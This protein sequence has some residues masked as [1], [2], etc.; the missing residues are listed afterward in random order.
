M[1]MLIFVFFLQIAS[2]SVFAQNTYT[3]NSTS[4]NW[5][6]SSKWTPAR[7]SISDSDVIIIDG[8][9]TSTVVIDSFVT[10]RVSRFKIIN[11]ADVTLSAKDVVDTL[12]IGGSGDSLVIESG[13]ALKLSGSK[14]V[15]I[16]LSQTATGSVGGR[17]TLEGGAHRLLSNSERALVFKAG[18]EF[19][20]NTGFTGNPFGTTV[21]NSVCF[22]AGST[23][24]YTAGSNPFGA[25][26]PNSVVSFEHG[27]KFVII[28]AATGLSFNGRTY[29]DIVVTGGLQVTGSGSGNLRFDTLR[30]EPGSSF[31]YNGTGSAKITVLG[32][33]TNGGNINLTAAGSIS[34]EGVEQ[35]MGGSNG[36]ISLT[37]NVNVSSSTVVT[38]KSDLSLNSGTLAAAGTMDFGAHRISGSGSFSLLPGSIMKIADCAGLD[39]IFLITGSKS[40]D[41]EASFFLYGT[42]TEWSGTLAPPKIRNLTIDGNSVISKNLETSG[43][44]EIRSG[45]LNVSRCMLS[46]YQPITG[47]GDLDCDSTAS[48]AIM[49]NMTGFSVPQNIQQLDSLFIGNPNGASLAGDLTVD[50][51]NLAGGKLIAGNHRLKIKTDAVNAGT[52]GYVDDGFTQILEQGKIAKFPLGRNGKYEPI[53]MGLPDAATAKEL[54]ISLTEKDS[55][56]AGI[57]LRGRTLLQAYKLSPEGNWNSRVA[58]LKITYRD[59]DIPNR[60]TALENTIKL[61]RITNGVIEEVPSIA[62]DTSANRIIP[63]TA[64]LNS[65]PQF[66][67]LTVENEDVNSPKIWQSVYR[68]TAEV[69]LANA[70]TQP[71]SDIGRLSFKV[72]MPKVAYDTLVAITFCR[73]LFHFSSGNTVQVYTDKL[74]ISSS[75]IF[76]ERSDTLYLR[77]GT[78]AVDTFN[79]SVDGIKVVPN[80]TSPVSNNGSTADSLALLIVSKSSGNKII[81]S[82]NGG[83][84]LIKLLP[85]ASFRPRWLPSSQFKDTT[86]G[87]NFVA[88][89][90][91]KST[92]QLEIQ[93]MFGNRTN[94]KLSLPALTPIQDFVTP[95][96]ANGQLVCPENYFSR[97]DDLNGGLITYKVLAYDKCEKIKLVAALLGKSDTMPS[98][99]VN[100]FAAPPSKVML[101]SVSPSDVF[102]SGLSAGETATFTIAVVDRYN[103]PVDGTPSWTLP[104]WLITNETKG[105]GG[106]FSPAASSSNIL[107]GD[108]L[109]RS[110]A[111]SGRF[112]SFDLNS[113]RIAY[114]SS[115]FYTGKIVLNF[116]ARTEGNEVLT[117]PLVIE[118]NVTTG[119]P[120]SLHLFT[121]SLRTNPKDPSD[122]PTRVLMLPAESKKF[123]VEFL[124][125]YG[126]HV[127]AVKST[128]VKFSS[129]A[130]GSFLGTALDSL[131]GKAY[132]STIF[133]APGKSN[134]FDDKT[135]NRIGWYVVR[136]SM[137]N[138]GAA[139]SIFVLVK[140]G[141]PARVELL[142]LDSVSLRVSDS[143]RS[144]E[145][146]RDFKF[147]ASDVFGNR[148]AG[149]QLRFAARGSGGFA[150]QDGTGKVQLASD[151]LAQSGYG[152]VEDSASA[153]IVPLTFVS[154]G[155]AGV[156][157]VMAEFN[158]KTLA[159]FPVKIIPGDPV[160]VRFLTKK[161]LARLA[162]QVTHELELTDNFLNRVKAKPNDTSLIRLRLVRGK[163]Y[164]DGVKYLDNENGTIKLNYR[165]HESDPDTAF[166]VSNYLESCDTAMVISEAGSGL[167]VLSIKVDST[168]KFAGDSI[169]VVVASA[170]SNAV[171]LYN[172]SPDSL[173]VSITEARP[174]C[175]C[176]SVKMP[177]ITGERILNGSHGY[178]ALRFDSVRKEVY[179]PQGSFFD[180]KSVLYLHSFGAA[181]FIVKVFDAR[182]HISSAPNRPM[183]F[184]ALG[185][186][187]Y[188]IKFDSTNIS[189]PSV[190]FELKYRVMPLDK[191]GNTN[192][193]SVTL[194]DIASNVGAEVDFGTSPKKILG[195]TSLSL[196]V[197]ALDQTLSA[198]FVVF[199]I[200][201]DD[202]SIQ[203]KSDT[204]RFFVPT[205]VLANEKKPDRFKILGSYPNPFNLSAVIEFELPKSCNVRVL[206][207]DVLGR[208]VKTIISDER[209]QSGRRGV[210]W[211][212]ENS[213]GSISASGIYWYVV[214]AE[215]VRGTGRMVLLK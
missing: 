181:S 139:D 177:F 3:W 142:N 144:S 49:G 125:Q 163:G 57:D 124:D 168:L 150:R 31:S 59:E 160:K 172:Y 23:Y 167:A 202:N 123:R 45:S 68:D 128:T 190:P 15:S 32:N 98:R 213:Q 173:T 12:L 149:Y 109:S 40:F 114:H 35:L 80:F 73:G 42:H 24:N 39:S 51:L 212:G 178:Y 132:L 197:T 200:K 169:R 94:D 61:F 6:D 135:P 29:P 76:G 158:G 126:N 119:S 111:D 134:T 53:E 101:L 1:R 55:L 37:G 171:P 4:G 46:V 165:S 136:A 21:L 14:A 209:A 116:R 207:Y 187:S 44:I 38:L 104:E 188:R 183:E 27:S 115:R 164:L 174:L 83:A 106:Y 151:T 54:M 140:G 58:G 204:V 11:G 208:L 103:N 145:S 199:V 191:F 2:Q 175:I 141:V 110:P 154:G 30:T 203:G 211:N 67:V 87:E 205:G 194:V 162:Q 195:E 91:G 52:N 71:A 155:K 146:S 8:S 193:D 122:L 82:A 74:P 129:S 153:G 120:I 102:S 48:L 148:S 182:A 185:V 206:I 108:M 16:I 97:E 156:D 127:D 69:R 112:A 96:P 66:L 28:K 201:R 56:P 176:D 179:L 50:V 72:R 215:G 159:A 113:M 198:G 85:G 7:L 43:A 157:T 19:F 79:V 17:L 75:S 189:P 147:A 90:N 5:S 192:P 130:G 214:E 26:A 92:V 65:L 166:L 64:G 152:S 196:R 180:S 133:R 84:E 89:Q 20:T 161:I 25:S 63:P 86:A 34:F 78:N 33:L 22:E 95:V 143:V 13:T 9:I 81:S 88:F 138:S 137:P 184:H 60:E 100:I 77:F 107:K 18:S 99:G 62:R 117:Q 118:F 10:S 70:A 186:S 210:V 47:V 36:S 121:D 131:S 105:G 93:D 170:D 41:A